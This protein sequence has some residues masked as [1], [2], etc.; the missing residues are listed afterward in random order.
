MLALSIVVGRKKLTRVSVVVVAAVVVLVLVVAIAAV[1]VVRHSL[2]DYTGEESVPGLGNDVSIKRDDTGIPQ[3]YAES[4]HDLFYAQ[5]FVHAQDRFFEM[6]YRRHV[7]AGRLSE[8]V[9]VNSEALAADKVIRTL[10]WRR[11]A[12]KELP[13]LNKSTR[14]YLQAYADGVNSYIADRSPSDLG[15][16]YTI[17]GSTVQLQ[18]IERWTPVDSLAWLKAMAWDLKTNFDS[19]LERAQI[20]T[21]VP[22]VSKVDE[23]FPSAPKSHKPIVTVGQMNKSHLP[24]GSSLGSKIR[25]GKKEADE[26]SMALEGSPAHIDTQQ[27]HKS[28][29]EHKGSDDKGSDKGS[30]K[31]LKKNEKNKKEKQDVGAAVT[32]PDAI[33]AA[34]AALNAVPQLVGRGDGIGSNSWVVAG[35]YTKSGKPLLANDPHL[36]LTVPGIWYQAGLHCR[37]VSR[38]CPFDVAGFGFSGMPGVFIGHNRNIGWGFTNM[39]ADVT[40]FYLEKIDGSSYRLDGK[41]VPLKQRTE[42]IKVAGSSAVTINVRSTDHGPIVSDV[43]TDTRFSRPK[44][45]DDAS[46][47]KPADTAARKPQYAVSLA[48]TALTPGRTADAIFDLDTAKNFSDMRAAARTFAVPGQNIVYADTAGHI[49]YQTPGKVPIRNTVVGGPAP[50]NGTWPVP[51]WDSDFDWQGYI[52]FDQLPSSLDPGDGFIATA[53]QEVTGPAYP[54]Y[55]GSDF[56]YGYRSQ[57][58]RDQ[59]QDAIKSGDKL[60][61][62]DMSTI[63]M[64]TE[65]EFARTLVK[66][67]LKVKTNKF[68]GEAVDLLRDWDYTEPADSAAA[69][70]FNAVWASVLTYAFAGEIPKPA[71]PNGSSRWMGAVAKLLKQPDNSWWDDKLTPN[72]VETRDEVLARAMTGARKELT[73]KLGKDPADWQWG[74]LHTLELKQSPLGSDSVPGI[75]R[76]VY[77]AGSHEVGGTT[78]VVDATSWSAASGNYIV[79]SGPSMRMVLDF[80]DLNKSTWVNLTGNSGH[81]FG[82]HY[83]DQLPRW[84]QG[85]TYRWPFTRSAVKSATT[86]T[87][88]LRP[89][90][91]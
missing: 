29:S 78:S 2:P 30:D 50:S 56:D 12:E 88:I 6:D 3:I 54:N 46:P 67:L 27:G 24:K 90:D 74:R 49:G 8:L 66:Y 36:A 33:N 34:G 51:G 25:I 43:L 53:N 39:G 57:S 61:R 38:D 22:S 60:T 41:N 76:W 86:D 42:H 73:A 5:G 45:S 17:L 20:H 16:S 81:P 28:D 35:K 63:Q 59:L 70:Y 52:K 87:L 48:W 79:T 26:W 14:D 9:G 80:K 89:D 72:V 47:H 7:T 64:S 23:L 75:V 15:L 1:T 19:E 37:T 82:K 77:N 91:E 18:D 4:S 10:G 71:T 85:K 68:T 21:T 62:S 40:D 31:K 13:M 84:L 65:N 55:L 32:G 83:L 44:K 69:A 58:I 11:V